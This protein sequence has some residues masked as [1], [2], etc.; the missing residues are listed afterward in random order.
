MGDTIT[1]KA[2]MMGGPL[3]GM[4]V[5]LDPDDGF[6]FAF[7][8]GEDATVVYKRTTALKHRSGGVYFAEYVYHGY[9]KRYQAHGAD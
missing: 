9:G 7:S 3:D 4:V 8:W 5:P 2:E 1:F 6:T